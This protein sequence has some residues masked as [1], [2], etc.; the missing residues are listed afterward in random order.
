[1][2]SIDNSHNR[3]NA[4][5]VYLIKKEK[6]FI[7]AL[8]PA[9]FCTLVSFAYILQTPEGLRLAPMTA[10][11]ISTIATAIIGIIFIKKFKS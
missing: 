7:I 6:P 2:V 11:I 8:L 5:S 9:I 1:M 4:A 10:N 3:I